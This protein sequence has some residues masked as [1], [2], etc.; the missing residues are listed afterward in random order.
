M[1][2]PLVNGDLKDLTWGFTRD[3]YYSVKTAYMLSKG[4][5]LDNFH[6]AWVD[7]W[8]FKVIPKVRRFLWR[9]CTNSLHVRALLK[10]SHIIEDE[11]CPWGCGAT[12]TPAHA[13]FKCPRVADLWADSGCEVMCIPDDLPTMCDLVASWRA[14]DTK[15][16]TKGAFLAWVIWGERD[17]VVFN[18]KAIPNQLLLDRV[19]GLALEYGNYVHNIY[20]TS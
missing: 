17:S 5:N 12:E 3:G 16:E 11:S 2:I 6:S 13:I 7:L 9:L 1:S 4:G 14:I 19:S 8:S 10:Q 15:V 18:N 20:P